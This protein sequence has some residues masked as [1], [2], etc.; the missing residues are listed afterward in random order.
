MQNQQRGSDAVENVCL[1][2]LGITGLGCMV[3]NLVEREER[4][5]QGIANDEQEKNAEQPTGKQR[6]KS[7]VLIPSLEGGDAEG[8]PGD[9][10][11]YGCGESPEK[12]VEP[13]QLCGADLRAENGIDGMSNDHDN[14]GDASQ[15]VD[16][17]DSVAG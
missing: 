12:V 11:E 4:H 10:K 14:N 1:E 2:Q 8:Q 9:E 3:E 17:K 6:T 7:P 15:Q 16:E 13:E 5:V